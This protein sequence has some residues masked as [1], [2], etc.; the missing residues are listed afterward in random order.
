MRGP[1]LKALFFFF[2]CVFFF[3]EGLQHPL[4][5]KGLEAR[6]QGLGFRVLQ[7]PER[8]Q[9]P[10]KIEYSPTSDHRWVIA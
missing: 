8:A 3:F 2:L 1:C 6:V 9:L 5:N 10:S 4:H 7:G